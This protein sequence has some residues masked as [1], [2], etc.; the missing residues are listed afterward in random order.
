MW[1]TVKPKAAVV[2][3]EP[4]YLLITIPPGVD[5]DIAKEAWQ[6]ALSKIE[7]ENK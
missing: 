3:T 7:K 6:E 2:R 1:S 5:P 4:A